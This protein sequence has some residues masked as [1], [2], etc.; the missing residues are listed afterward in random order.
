M[1]NLQKI[2]AKGIRDFARLPNLAHADLEEVTTYVN[3]VGV[4]VGGI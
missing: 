3:V 1:F 2:T 4:L